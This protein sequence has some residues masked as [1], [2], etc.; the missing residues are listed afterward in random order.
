MRAPVSASEPA[1]V[2]LATVSPAEQVG[3]FL[4]GVTAGALRHDQRFAGAVG[5]RLTPRRG[6][7]AENH[8][9][10]AAPGP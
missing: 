1:P 2:T 4:R 10:P 5:Q 3:E 9:Q 8:G 7:Q 6:R